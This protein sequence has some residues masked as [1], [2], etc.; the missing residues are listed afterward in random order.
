M[1]VCA[2]NYR[3]WDSKSGRCVCILRGHNCPVL[4]VKAC[5]LSCE[6]VHIASGDMNGYM[7]MWALRAHKRRLVAHVKAHDGP[8][9]ALEFSPNASQLV[10]VAGD[11]S[12]CV[13]GVTA[14]TEFSILHRLRNTSGSP[15]LCC[16]FRPDSGRLLTGDHDG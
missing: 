7:L 12:L 5:R 2:P 13:Y 4:A 6:G 8:I 15:L 3:I 10:S 16:S 9:H 14:N 1:C 11:G